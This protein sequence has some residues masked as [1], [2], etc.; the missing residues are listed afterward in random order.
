MMMK[1]M[2]TW[3]AEK[4]SR[5]AFLVLMIIAV[6]IF[7]LFYGIGFDELY[8]DNPNFNAPLFTDVLI[9]FTLLLL[10]IAGVIVVMSVIRR[11]RLAGREGSMANGV[12]ETRINRCVAIFTLLCLLVTFLLGSASSISVNGEPFRETLW[13]KAADM[14]VSTSLVL[15][16]V[17]TGSVAFGAVWSKKNKRK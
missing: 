7:A 5:R 3:P 10:M 16:L 8:I 2:Q 12:P 17:T 14:F 15:L 4:I 6:V 11:G 9:V 13:L 1:R